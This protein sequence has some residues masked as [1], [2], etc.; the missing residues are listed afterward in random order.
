MGDVSLLSSP[1]AQS[2]WGEERRG[3]FSNKLAKSGTDYSDS[4]IMV[5]YKE[6]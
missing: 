4:V 6:G 3:E 2:A 5:N 1:H